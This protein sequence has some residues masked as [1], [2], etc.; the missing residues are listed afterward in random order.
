MSYFTQ[1]CIIHMCELEMTMTPLTLSELGQDLPLSTATL[2]LAQGHIDI[3]FTFRL[4]A[5]CYNALT[6]KLPDKPIFETL[7]LTPKHLLKSSLL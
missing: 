7:F 1:V 4:L 5:Q 2:C 6:A 3:F